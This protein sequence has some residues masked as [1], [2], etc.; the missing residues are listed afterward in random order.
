MKPIIYIARA[1]GVAWR[2][3]EDEV[4]VLSGSDSSLFI[5]NA[6][7]GEI[8]EAADGKTTLSDIVVRRIIP[9]FEVEFEQAYEDA[10]EFV[11]ALADE[12]ILLVSSQP[13]DG[14]PEP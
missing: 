14:A 12:G 7:A 8:W 6:V 9:G 5:L 4:I 1:P 2:R 3:L 13:L 10:A 11:R